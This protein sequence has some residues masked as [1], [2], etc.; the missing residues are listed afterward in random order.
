[1]IVADSG[2]P[3]EAE[4]LLNL[5]KKKTTTRQK[6]GGT[7]I[8]YMTVFEIL[9]EHN[10]SLVIKEFKPGESVNTKA[11]IVRFDNNAEYLLITNREREIAT[12]CSQ[13]DNSGSQTDNSDYD[14]TV[15][16]D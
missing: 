4:T 10:A 3:F 6:E 5:G 7:G 16:N 12:M 9:R 14:L 11:V 1:M 15:L 13:A 8:G 2:I